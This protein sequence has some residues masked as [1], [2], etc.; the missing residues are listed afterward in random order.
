MKIGFSTSLGSVSFWTVWGIYE[1]LEI[2]LDP[3]LFLAAWV[4]STTIN[5]K[6]FQKWWKPAT[7]FSVSFSRSK[8]WWKLQHL[9][10]SSTSVTVS[11]FLMASLSALG[12]KYAYHEE[13]Q[14][15]LIIFLEE[16]RLSTVYCLVWMKRAQV[17]PY[18]G[19]SDC[20]EYSSWSD[21][22]LDFRDSLWSCSEQWTMWLFFS[23]SFLSSFSFL[24]RDNLQY[25]CI[26]ATIS[27][28]LGMQL[29]GCMFCDPNT[30][31]CD[32]KNFDSLLWAT[33]TVFQVWF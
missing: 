31:L 13:E 33:V 20:S 23:A 22:F 3:K 4:S 10:L 26:N 25:K 21:S 12:T 27:S 32:R 11:M 28:I 19:H 2:N 29:F 8:C 15:I 18:W 17:S 30:G 24:G 16:W 9:A 7:L 5:Q 6:H 14:I 1:K